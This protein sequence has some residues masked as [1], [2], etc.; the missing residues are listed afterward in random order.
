MM[1]NPVR[2]ELALLF[3]VR[4]EGVMRVRVVDPMGRLVLERQVGLFAGENR[5]AIPTLN[6]TPGGYVLE[7]RVG[8][9]RRIARFVKE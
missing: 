4:R 5:V 1:G 8:E 6:L 3:G 2:D 7:T 9:E